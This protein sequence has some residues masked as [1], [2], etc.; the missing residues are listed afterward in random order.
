M[1]ARRTCIIE[2]LCKE[3]DALEKVAD[4]VGHVGLALGELARMARWSW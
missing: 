3:V 4:L 1:L 2:E